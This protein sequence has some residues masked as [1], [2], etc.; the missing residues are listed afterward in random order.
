ME[1]RSGI[2]DW[3]HFEGDV[4]DIFDAAKEWRSALKGVD[5]PWL[6]WH[7]YEPWTRLQVKLVRQI[8]WTPVIGYD[9]DC[10]DNS[11]IDFGD[12]ITIDFNKRL[13][14]KKMYMHFPLEFAFLWTDRIAFWHS[15]LLVRIP[16]LT[17]TAKKFESLQDGWVA[18]CPQ[19]GRGMKDWFFPSKHRI[20]ELI[21]LTTAS[22][23]EDQYAKGAGWWKHF[24]MH[25]NCPSDAERAKRSRYYYD[26]GTGVMYWHKRYGGKVHYIDSKP[27]NEG[28]CTSI[29]NPAYIKIKKE[30]GRKMVGKQLEKN[31]NI[32]DV[33]AKLGISDLL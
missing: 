17:E 15:D 16:L 22:A 10:G 18:G 2:G 14:F 4:G 29:N 1:M 25:P 12:E 19:Y 30:P 28:H 20:W 9:P 3:K 24:W 27:F 6:C 33:A 23:S 8:G 21:G 26:H 11:L 5:K 32:S 7:V 13:G 31:F